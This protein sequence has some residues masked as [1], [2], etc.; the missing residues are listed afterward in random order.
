MVLDNK[1]TLDIELTGSYLFISQQQCLS[2]HYVF[3]VLSLI[4]EYVRNFYTETTSIE[5]QNKQNITNN[6][7]RE[8]FKMAN[9]RIVKQKNL[10]LKMLIKLDILS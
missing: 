1:V 2:I 4:Q 9:N 6:I 7:L 8:I 3:T 10:K 5:N